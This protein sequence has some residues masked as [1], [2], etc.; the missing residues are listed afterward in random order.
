MIIPTARNTKTITDL[1]EKAVELLEETRKGGPT[2]IF[3]HSKPK[4][5]MLS[6]EEYSNMMEMLEDYFDSLRAKELEENPEK[7]G[8]SLEALIKKYKLRGISTY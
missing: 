6:I 3:S 7:G 4:A 5:V 1:R 2:F 8:I